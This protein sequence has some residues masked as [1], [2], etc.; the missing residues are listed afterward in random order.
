[1]MV[2]VEG[3][4]AYAAGEGEPECI[5]IDLAVD[6]SCDQ[7]GGPC[8]GRI[9]LTVE[10]A[11]NLIVILQT[12]R[13]SLRPACRPWRPVF[14]MPTPETINEREYQEC[15]TAMAARIAMRA[16]TPGHAFAFAFVSGFR[17]A[18]KWAQG[19]AAPAV[20]EGGPK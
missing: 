8:D 5:M 17:S 6:E 1:M 10:A 18:L 4:R 7:L 20:E 2:E 13:D 15:K 19:L 12:A 3:V 9:V 11:E 14:A 16:M